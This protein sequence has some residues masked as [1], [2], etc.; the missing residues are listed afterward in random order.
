MFDKHTYKA[1]GVPRPDLE[2]GTSSVRSLPQATTQP[3]CNDFNMVYDIDNFAQAD[4]KEVLELLNLDEKVSLLAV[5][6]TVP[7]LPGARS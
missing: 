2:V 3:I 4:L 5:S 1:V 6:R 7:E